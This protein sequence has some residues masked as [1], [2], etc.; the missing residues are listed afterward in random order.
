VE[1]S[2]EVLVSLSFVACLSDPGHELLGASAWRFR[3]GHQ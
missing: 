3:R 1:R 2:T